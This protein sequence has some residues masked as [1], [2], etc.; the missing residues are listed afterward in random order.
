MSKLILSPGTAVRL[1]NP[2]TC[3]QKLGGTI[4]DVWPDYNHPEK[5]I[6]GV[7]FPRGGFVRE[8]TAVKAVELLPF[9]EEGG[10]DENP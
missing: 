8:Q 6:V 10:N 4:I 3:W 9:E 7:I 5:S 1:K 2:Q